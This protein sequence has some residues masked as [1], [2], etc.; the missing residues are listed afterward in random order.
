MNAHVTLKLHIHVHVGIYSRSQKV[1][2]LFYFYVTF[3]QSAAI[4][5]ALGGG[6][7]TKWNGTDLLFCL[8][9][10]ETFLTATV[11]MYGQCAYVTSF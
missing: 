9:K 2:V 5:H 7:I 11:Y 6:N 1:S 8:A 3:L 10:T 4:N